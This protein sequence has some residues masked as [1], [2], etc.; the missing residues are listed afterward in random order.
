MGGL[1]FVAA[2]ELLKAENGILETQG[3]HVADV[4]PAD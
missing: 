2:A 4:V 3:F 1:R